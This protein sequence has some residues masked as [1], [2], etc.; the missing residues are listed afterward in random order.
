MQAGPAAAPFLTGH[1][2]MTTTRIIRGA[3]AVRPARGTRRLN[4]SCAASTGEAIKDKR[5]P[6]T[7]LT[8][9]L[10][11]VS[12]SHFLRGLP[13]PADGWMPGKTLGPREDSF[14]F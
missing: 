13:L 11:Y 3:S 10:G 6:V 14:S 8:G 9:F 1:H 2:R 5:I 12:S 4:L 7:V